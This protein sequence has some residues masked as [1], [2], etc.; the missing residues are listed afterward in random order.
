MES[1]A[2]D[3]NYEDD[4]DGDDDVSY[5]CDDHDAFKLLE[6]PKKFVHNARRV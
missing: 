3:D 6:F 2:C 1:N 4:N 5:V